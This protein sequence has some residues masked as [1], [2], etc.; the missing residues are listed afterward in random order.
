MS[1][2]TAE[3][4]DDPNG[5]SPFEEWMD[6]LDEIT[7]AAVDTAIREVLEVRGQNLASTSWL[8]PLGDGLYEFRITHSTKRL[9]ALYESQGKSLPK[10]TNRILVRVFVHF[11]GA[12][13]CLLLGAYDKLDDD[14]RKRQAREIALARKRLMEWKRRR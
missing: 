13:I 7:W 5:N 14:S 3:P 2:W 1:E 10:G 4:Y 6:G 9:M 12:K 8:T 11:H